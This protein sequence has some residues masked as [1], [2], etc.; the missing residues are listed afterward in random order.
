MKGLSLSLFVHARA[1]RH[2]LRGIYT[3]YVVTCVLVLF[4]N[5]GSAS[6]IMAP[7]GT[8]ELQAPGPD[9]QK[10]KAFRKLC[11]TRTP[12]NRAQGKLLANQHTEPAPVDPSFQ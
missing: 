7:T 9:C 4:F 5:P 10:Q 12:H 6:G 1:V 3:L 2:V 8:K 11:H